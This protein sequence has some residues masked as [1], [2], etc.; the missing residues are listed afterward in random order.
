MVE[1]AGHQAGVAARSG[2]SCLQAH[3]GEF[4][5]RR[6]MACLGRIVS[7]GPGKAERLLGAAPAVHNRDGTPLDPIEALRR[8]PGV[9]G[10]GGDPRCASEAEMLPQVALGKFQSPPIRA[11]E[12]GGKGNAT[13]RRWRA[14]AALRGTPKLCTFI[15][16]G[17]G[18]ECKSVLGYIRKLW[19]WAKTGRGRPALCRLLDRSEGRLGARVLSPSRQQGTTGVGRSR[20]S[21][22]RAPANRDPPK[23]LVAPQRLQPAKRMVVNLYIFSRIFT[24]RCLLEFMS[25]LSGNS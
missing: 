16:T 12:A 14:D 19:A 4:A 20:P 8:D 22:H 24:T 7:G 9:E 25:P 13:R 15:S 3:A 18:A 21:A 6:Q 1:G 23:Q 2:A 17:C 10:M 11:T 5:G